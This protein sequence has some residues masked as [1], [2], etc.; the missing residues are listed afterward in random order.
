MLIRIVKLT[1]RPEK[2]NDFIAAFELRKGLIASFKGCSGVE[3]LRDID[4]TNIFFTYSKWADKAALEEY[5]KSELFNTTWDEVKQLFNGKP[6]AW[7]V[8]QIS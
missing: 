3:L 2:A 5:R 7:S 6:E 4:H 1:F 8:E